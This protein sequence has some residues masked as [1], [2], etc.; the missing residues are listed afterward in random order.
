MIGP[1]LGGLL[2]HQHANATLSAVC[3][4]YGLAFVLVLLFFN[5]HVGVKPAVK[6]E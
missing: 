5:K 6:A 1:A 3:C 2:S 4:C